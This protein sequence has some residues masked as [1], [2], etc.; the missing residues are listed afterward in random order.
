MKKT[1]LVLLSALLSGAVLSGCTEAEL[2]Y[3]SSLLSQMAAGTEL[4]AEPAAEAEPS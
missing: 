3:A 4:P 2:N 1:G